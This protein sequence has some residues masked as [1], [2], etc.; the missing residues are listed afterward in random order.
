LNRKVNSSRE[1]MNRIDNCVSEEIEEI[2][3][4]EIEATNESFSD[5]PYLPGKGLMGQAAEAVAERYGAAVL[6]HAIIWLDYLDL[7]YDAGKEV[8]NYKKFKKKLKEAQ[9]R[10]CKCIQNAAN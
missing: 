7:G 3:Q 4:I 10:R 8:W 2:N 9:Q 1:V 6:E 5:L